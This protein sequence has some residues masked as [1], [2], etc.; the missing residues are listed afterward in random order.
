[1]QR[2]RP[3]RLQPPPT[4]TPRRLPIIQT[5]LDI[6]FEP[7]LVFVGPAGEGRTVLDDVAE[8]PLDAEF[9]EVLSGQGQGGGC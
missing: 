9:V 4:P 6:L 3:R 5:R 7:T 2:T 1:M 8:G